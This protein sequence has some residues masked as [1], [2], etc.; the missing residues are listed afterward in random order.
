MSGA[1]GA[2][3]LVSAGYEICEPG[4]LVVTHLKAGDYDAELSSTGVISVVRSLSVGLDSEL[5]KPVAALTEG[6]KVLFSRID[7]RVEVTLFEVA[8]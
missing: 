6:L 8:A 5:Y 2:A 4:R 7:D 1:D 3:S